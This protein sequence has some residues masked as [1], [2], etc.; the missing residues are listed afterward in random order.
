MPIKYHEIWNPK[1]TPQTEKA[2]PEQIK[3]SAGGF[4]FEV[5]EW[6]QLERFILIGSEGGSYY[7]TE[8]KLTKENA[9]NVQKCL[10]LHGTQAIDRIVDISSAG[11]APKRAPAIFALAMASGHSNEDV[12]RAAFQ[13][14]PK[15]CGTPTDLYAFVAAMESFRNWGKLAR[16]GITNW[17]LA[18]GP[19][20]LAYQASKYQSRDGWSMRDI[21][22]LCH[23][24]RST[25]EHKEFRGVYEWVAKGWDWVGEAPH[26]D[27][28]MIPIWAFE[29]AKRAERKEE[30]VRLIRDF[31]LVRECVPTQFLT[32]PEVWEALLEDMP[33]MAMLRNLATMTRVGLLKPLSNGT[34]TVCER[35][36]NGDWIRDA[37]VHPLSILVGKNTYGQ[38]H[39]ERGGNSWVPVSQVNAALEDA[40]YLAFKAVE[41]TGKR[42]MLAMDISGSMD[43]PVI[44]GMPGITPRVGTGVLSSVIA[45]NEDQ[46]L[47]VAFT[48]GGWN[49]V[50]A[51]CGITPVDVGPKK[52]LDEVIRT[53][54]RLQMG[55]AGTDCSLPMI[56]ATK[57]KIEVDCFVVLT[58]NET[59]AGTQHP[60]QALQEY[61]Q[62]MGIPAKMAVIAMTA[63]KF[64]IAD[65]SDAGMVDFVGMDSHVPAVLS[66]FAKD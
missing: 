14:L 13:A 62:K 49:S 23:F 28:N 52:R 7:A 41:P 1:K 12:R 38:G 59:W 30:I 42:F 36:R 6:T 55:S 63:S 34:K 64:S 37:R 4:S 46:C 33:L 51:K 66:D 61:R 35:L 65:P 16:Q 39:G 50:G 58:D 10:D 53:L 8:Q 9:K 43:S 15:V 56:Y 45:S 26:D 44:A 31:R 60:F 3:N 5:N 17:L 32:E 19:R 48:N 25:Y 27:A 57:N 21:M 22:R 2:K 29:R 11:R 54:Q 18:K 40:F 47:A 20:N 24:N